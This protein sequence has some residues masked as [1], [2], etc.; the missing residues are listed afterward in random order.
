MATLEQSDSISVAELLTEDVITTALD[1]NN[2]DDVFNQLIDLLAEAKSCV[3]TVA[4][5]WVPV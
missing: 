3:G 5:E 4:G 2:R 1:V